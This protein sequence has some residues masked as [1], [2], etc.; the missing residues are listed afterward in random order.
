MKYNLLWLQEE[1]K[2][3]VALEYQF[4]WGHTPKKEGSVD[5]SCL[6]QWWPCE[7]EVDGVKYSSAEQYMMAEKARMFEDEEICAQILLGKD[8]KEIK[9]LGRKTRNFNEDTWKKYCVQ[10]VLE[11]NKAKFGQNLE[12]GKFLLQTGKRI[13]AEAS[14]VDQIWGIGLSEQDQAAADPT[15]WQGTN[16]LGFVLMEVRDMIEREV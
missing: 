6:S 13:I 7:F 9:A 1:Y 11:G 5:K 14:P 12:L 3:G 16:L 15:K 8:P 2:K 4:F 10:I